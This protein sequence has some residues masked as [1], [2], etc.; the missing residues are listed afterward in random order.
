MVEDHA[1]VEQ[2]NIAQF[3]TLNGDC[4]AFS[5]TVLLKVQERLKNSENLE[6]NDCVT[7][8]Q[9]YVVTGQTIR[10]THASVALCSSVS[11]EWVFLDSEFG[12]AVTLTINQPY[13]FQGIR[14]KYELLWKDGEIC[15]QKTLTNGRRID[16]QFHRRSRERTFMEVSVSNCFKL[17]MKF[18][19][20]NWVLGKV[21]KNWFV[22]FDVAT[23][24]FSAGNA[25]FSSFDDVLEYIKAA[26]AK[27]SAECIAMAGPWLPSHG[28]L[29]SLCD[30][31]KNDHANWTA[32][33]DAL[34][35][36]H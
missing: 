14:V 25:K 13:A 34:I 29:K 21:R 12:M 35:I 11:N 26:E 27:R 31:W 23:N 3:M 18:L 6:L 28:N 4:F 22:T 5:D 20:R 30:A 36:N 2:A 33:M 15:G 24:Q 17:N 1:S 19:G 9:W 7:S 32:K 8:I 16:L 10:D